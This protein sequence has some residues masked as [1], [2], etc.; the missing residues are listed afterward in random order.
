MNIKE[1][2]SE[3]VRTADPKTHVRHRSS[4]WTKIQFTVD[5]RIVRLPFLVDTGSPV[6]I[7]SIPSNINNKVKLSNLL[8]KGN[9][10]ETYYSLL[11]E[12]IKVVGGVV[13]D[14][15]LTRDVCIP[16]IKLHF[17]DM[18]EDKCILGMDILSYFEFEY[19][20]DSGS[21]HSGSIWLTNP[22]KNIDDIKSWTGNKDL[23]YIDPDLSVVSTGTE[24]MGSQSSMF[25]KLS[26]R[27]KPL[28]ERG[29][30]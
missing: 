25:E 21:S 14:F 24:F 30:N 7:V 28:S 27:I 9:G 22:K 16:E 19:I 15:M 11:H 26:S 10:T 29:E 23:Y 8:D 4:Y 5:S 13:K 1:C 17:T 18:L 6:T 3:M 2:R 20:K 12:E